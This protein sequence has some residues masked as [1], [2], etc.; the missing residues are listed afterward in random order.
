M[1]DGEIWRRE[2]RP[3][4]FDFSS[5]ELNCRADGLAREHHPVR[6]DVSLV[7]S[8]GVCPGGWASVESLSGALRARESACIESG[9]HV[10]RVVAK[11]R[12]ERIL[13]AHEDSV[14][15]GLFWRSCRPASTARGRDQPLSE[16]SILSGEFGDKA[17][18]W[19][20]ATS[21]SCFLKV[22]IVPSDRWRTASRWS[23]IRELCTQFVDTC[24][25][26]R[27]RA[28]GEQG[29]VREQPQ[30]GCL[31]RRAGGDR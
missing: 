26:E 8:P 1:L 17:H 20:K 25:L 4:P 22:S 19:T 31:Y 13:R 6:D 24:T 3:R 28:G 18:C 27:G 11:G 5:R 30:L 2:R 10:G 21:I 9:R 7:V 29:G 16:D 15:S 14:L 12:V 23:R